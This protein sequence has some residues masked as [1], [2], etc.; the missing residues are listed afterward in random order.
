MVRIFSEDSFPLNIRTWSWSWFSKRYFSLGF[1]LSPSFFRE[2]DHLF[3]S[4]PSVCK[5]KW[6]LILPSMILCIVI[7]QL[8]ME[9]AFSARGLSMFTL[10]KLLPLLSFRIVARLWRI[11][12]SGFCVHL[13]SF[14]SER[15]EKKK[16]LL[17]SYVGRESE[18]CQKCWYQTVDS[19]PCF[20]GVSNIYLP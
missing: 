16:H 10:S 1:Q 6:L 4:T 3:F 12:F 11:H 20:Y 5:S 13:N 9:Q 2:Y 15:V 8:S 18:T 7:P 19:L 17:E 14:F